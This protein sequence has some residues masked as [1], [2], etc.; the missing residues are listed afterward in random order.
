M[1]SHRGIDHQINPLAEWD[2]SIQL[3]A[4]VRGTLENNQDQDQ[5][6]TLEVA[7]PF[8]D[9]WLAPNIPPKPGDQWR[10]NVFRIDYGLERME[11]SAWNPTNGPSFHIPAK[12]GTLIFR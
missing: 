5:G 6:W 3:R 2:S 10:V 4:V 7:I 8:E 11:L 12:F 1:R 9:L